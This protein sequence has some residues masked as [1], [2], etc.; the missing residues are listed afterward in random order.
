MS[1]NNRIVRYWHYNRDNNE[2]VEL[3]VTHQSITAFMLLRKSV[4][5]MRCKF[6]RR[7]VPRS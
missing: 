7:A 3:P 4:C 6:G 5:L 1:A 2:V